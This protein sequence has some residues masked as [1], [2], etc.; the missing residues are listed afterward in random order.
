MAFYDWNH[1]GEK[2]L[3]DDYLEYNI[4]RKSTQDSGSTGSSSGFFS[5][6]FIGFVIIYIFIH[7]YGA[8]YE[9]VKPCMA[10]GCSENRIDSSIY[11]IK[12]SKE[13]D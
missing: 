11:C 13:Y 4:Y 2:N 12:H 3:V 9:A 1:D 5:K 6:M 8:C 10:I 7:I